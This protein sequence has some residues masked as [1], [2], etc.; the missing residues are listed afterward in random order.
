[1]T[2]IDNHTFARNEIYVN[3]I[4]FFS[5]EEV[6][7]FGFLN[8]GQQ[9]HETQYVINR[10]DLQLLLSQ[11][12][13][14]IEILWHIENLFVLPHEVPASLNL[15]DLFGTTQVFEANRIQLDIPFYKGADGELKPSGNNDLFFVQEVVPLPGARKNS[16]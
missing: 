10:K 13:T 6:S 15:I 7:L 1:M 12:K 8:Q 14:G 2:T 5:K 11:N 4:V 16:F 3:E 9:F